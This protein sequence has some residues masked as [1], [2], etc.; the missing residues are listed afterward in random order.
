VI[1]D[2][3]TRLDF[4]A[5]TAAVDASFVPLRV[6]SRSAGAFRG[7]VIAAHSGGVGFSIVDATPHVV[8]RTPELIERAPGRHLKLGIQLA[9]TGM[10]VQD[11]REVVLNPGEVAIYDTGTPYTLEFDHDFRCLVVMYPRTMS[12]IP[13]ADLSQ[14]TATPLSSAA[15]LGPVVASCLLSIATEL[16][17]LD[18]RVGPRMAQASVHLVDSL[19]LR[20]LELSDGT[21]AA[22]RRFREVA[23]FIEQ[24]LG[25]TDLTPAAIAHAN[26]MS[27]RSLHSLFRSRGAS[28]STWITRRRLH[29][30]RADLTD[31]ARTDESVSTIASRWGFPDPST[32][33]RAF[34]R[35]FGTSPRSVRARA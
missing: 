20:E 33:S 28:V 9:G 2:S 22:P 14:L 3:M 35:E 7:S 13:P 15:G 31:P 10:L 29:R 18:T 1:I 24:R 16:G 5:F 27:V 32:F 21:L 12:V 26:F 17:R 19:L 34:R 11:G 23:E 30:C 8:E 4:E 25:S 6:S